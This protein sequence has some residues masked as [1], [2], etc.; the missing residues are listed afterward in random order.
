MAHATVRTI[1]IGR[2]SDHAEHGFMPKDK[3]ISAAAA[4]F[5]VATQNPARTILLLKNVLGCR[6]GVLGCNPKPRPNDT[7]VKE[8][9][10]LL[11]RLESKIQGQAFYTYT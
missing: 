1:E 9:H 10:I 5:W 6:R 4:G 8:R 3:T 2:L 11:Y 7:V